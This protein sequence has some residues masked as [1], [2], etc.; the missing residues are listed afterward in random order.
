MVRVV[1]IDTNLPLVRPERDERL[2][3]GSSYAL[4]RFTSKLK[5]YSITEATM[6][7]DSFDQN[8]TDAILQRGRF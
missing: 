2:L 7:G 1:T 8:T 3:Y 5:N 6:D 4:F